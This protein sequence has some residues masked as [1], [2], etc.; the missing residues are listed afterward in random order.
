MKNCYKK[1]AK[2]EAIFVGI[3]LHKKTWHVTIRT[4]D[5]E[6]FNSNIPGKWDALKYQLIKYK[7]HPIHAVYEAGYFGFWIHD[8]LVNFGADCIVTPPSLI[9]L[10][11]GNKVKTD[12]RDSSKLALLLAKGMLK[13]VHVPTKEERFHRQVT[14]RR[15]QLVN[16]RV[17]TQ[18]RIKAELQLYG[19]DL[20]HPSGK[21]TQVYFENLSRIRFKNYWMQQGFNQLL[22][23]Y[24]FLDNQIGQQT[25]L[26]RELSEEPRYKDKVKILCTIPGVGILVAMELLL[27][28]Q[29]I[30]RFQ[31]ADQL[32]AYVGLTP[33]Q[34]S[35][36]EK[37]RMGRI[38]C[39]GKKVLRAM[40]VQASWQLIRKDG[41]MREKYQK[42]KARGG[43]KRAIIAIARTL[44]IRMRRLLLDEVPYVSGIISSS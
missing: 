16:D 2:G 11:Y 37:I 44:V 6:L 24:R 12:R 32:A 38:T 39:I 1:L 34:Y 5:V 35:S 20:P 18:S 41:V 17:R 27:E 9:P 28:L 26:I 10:E 31:K 8:H 25:K 3:D 36:A 33:S 29:D 43:G 7:S 42:I 40:L 14:R 13:R 4:A 23:Q 21:W 19:I 22:E 30:S 15:R